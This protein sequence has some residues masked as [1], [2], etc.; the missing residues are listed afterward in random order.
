MKSNFVYQRFNR[1]PPVGQIFI[2]SFLVF[3]VRKS[4]LPGSNSRSNVSEGYE[5]PLSYQ[6]YRRCVPLKFSHSLSSSTVKSSFVLSA[7]TPSEHTPV[8]TFTRYVYLNLFKFIVEL[9]SYTQTLSTVH[10]LS[11]HKSRPGGMPPSTGRCLSLTNFPHG[12][13]ARGESI[14]RLRHIFA[15]LLYSWVRYALTQWQI[16]WPLH[17]SLLSNVRMY[18]HH[19]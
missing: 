3:F 2:L 12:S 8:K 10:G 19:I 18:G 7:P 17:A 11:C 14:H 5:V 15:R 6:G 1:S 4:R 13:H 16:L 9:V